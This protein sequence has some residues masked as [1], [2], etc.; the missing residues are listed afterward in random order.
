[1]TR[2]GMQGYL[3]VVLYINMS[4]IWGTHISHV[5]FINASGHQTYVRLFLG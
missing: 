5:V 4:I 3:F 2:L 1:M